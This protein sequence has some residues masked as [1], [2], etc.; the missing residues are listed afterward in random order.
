MQS[1]FLLSEALNATATRGALQAASTFRVVDEGQK[2][3]DQAKGQRDLYTQITISVTL[4]LFAFLTF[5]V[6]CMCL[7]G[8]FICW[9]DKR[10]TITNI[11][12][13]VP[14]TDYAI[15]MGISIRC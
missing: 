14:G 5:C 6:S 9:R 12:L 2:Y 10:K 8:K 7:K 15:E 11:R 3:Q 4:G 13:F 1:V